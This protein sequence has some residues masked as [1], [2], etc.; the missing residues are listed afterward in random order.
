M[1]TT[2]LLLSPHPIHHDQEEAALLLHLRH[3]RRRRHGGCPRC[4]RFRR[5][6]KRQESSTHTSTSGPPRGRL[7]SAPALNPAVAE[8][9][10]HTNMRY[11]GCSAT[12][13]HSCS[14]AGIRGLTRA[15]SRGR[16][17]APA[18]LLLSPASPSP[19]PPSAKPGGCKDGGGGAPSPS[20][21]V[22]P[23]GTPARQE[24][25]L[26]AGDEEKR[27]AAAR[28]G[29]VE[30]ESG[31]PW[32]DLLGGGVGRWYFHSLLVTTF[33]CRHARGTLPFGAAFWIPRLLE[34]LF[35]VDLGS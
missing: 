10:S 8:G 29:A 20:L 34:D 4:F 23:Y 26:G 14:G 2:S 9:G 24:L 13:I 11:R 30:A 27:P 19:E 33:P 15:L 22:K 7:R 18:L 32:R 21:V 6:G 28:S 31:P 12:A 25:R 5:Q 35:V 1:A 17:G 16:R 3:N